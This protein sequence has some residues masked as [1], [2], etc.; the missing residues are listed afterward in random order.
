[1][2]YRRRARLGRQVRPQERPG[3]RGLSRTAR[4][5]TSRT[6]A[7]ARFCSNGS[8]TL[9]AEL[10]AL[11]ETLSCARS[12]PRSRSR[13]GDEA[14]GAGISRHAGA[15]HGR[16]G[17]NSSSLACATWGADLPAKR[18]PGDHSAAHGSRSCR[19]PT[20][21]DGGH[22]TLEFGPPDFIQI[23]REVNIAMVA[24]PWSCCE[25][26][27]GRH[28]TRPVLRPGQFHPA[29]G[30]AAPA[31]PWASRAMRR[32]WPGR[33]PTPAAT[34]SKMPISSRKICSN[35]RTLAHGPQ[36]LRSGASRPAARRGA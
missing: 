9:P 29:A 20:R 19:S 5:P 22:I 35:R 4:N 14:A 24:R 23:N 27:P 26:Q 12:C 33:R 30:A 3:A 1:M 8:P 36:P 28:G 25:P 10:A 13:P 21:V 16:C 18:R 15:E 34:A 32:W 11:V 31:G 7:A 2:A 17:S 6:S